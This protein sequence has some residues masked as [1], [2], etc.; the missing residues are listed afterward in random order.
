VKDGETGFH[1]PA[2]DPDALAERL[3]ELMQDHELREKMGRQASEYAK[4]FSWS[5]ITDQVLELYAA[6]LAE[7]RNELA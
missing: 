1:V 4:E 2:A 5:I 7:Y 3:I 6:V